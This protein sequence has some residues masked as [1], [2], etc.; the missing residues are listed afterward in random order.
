MEVYRNQYNM[1]YYNQMLR[2]DKKAHVKKHS[3]NT[4]FTSQEVDI[5]DYLYAPD[6]WKGIFYTLYFTFIP[7]L[8]GATFLFFAVAGGDY[9]NFKLL[10]ISAFLIVW[11]IG[12]EIVATMLL[13]AI[14]IKFLRFKRVL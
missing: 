2:A 12:Y 13:S 8:T 4:S 3:K 10:D 1:V 7:Y 9:A 5:Q 14:F 11:I 6:D